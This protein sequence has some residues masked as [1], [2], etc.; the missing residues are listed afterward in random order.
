LRK[1]GI[2]IG[3]RKK[4]STSRGRLLILKYGGGSKKVPGQRSVPSVPSVDSKF[5]GLETE[6]RAE[7]RM[8]V[9]PGAHSQ[10]TG[11][12]ADPQSS[13]SRPSVS[14]TLKSNK[15]EGTERTEGRPGTFK[16]R[17]PTPYPVNPLGR[18]QHIKLTARR[19]RNKR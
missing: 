7:D 3:Y 17:T 15:T 6:G 13:R 9:A 8:R 16:E 1:I 4:R 5:N 10:R 2:T 11:A 18:A 19:K 12:L 14:N